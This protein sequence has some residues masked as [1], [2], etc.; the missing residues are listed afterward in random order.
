VNRRG[1]ALLLAVALLAGLGMIA[2]TAFTLARTERVAGLA[3][4]ADVQALAAAD[5]AAAEAL[6]GW[7]RVQTPTFPG[8]ELP[9]ARIT[10][11]GPADGWSVV[12]ALGGPIFAVRAWGV[13]R[14][15]GGNP[16]AARRL[17][18]LVRLDSSGG[19]DSL[20]PRVN[21]RGWLG[22]VP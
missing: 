20:R 9:L 16:I 1:I 11:P 10:L 19:R 14:D 5:A 8:D 21:P 7:P 15:A 12:R 18:L 4:L 3:A 17:E 2:M 6:R 22:L 13:R